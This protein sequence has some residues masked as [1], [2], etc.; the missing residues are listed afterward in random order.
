MASGTLKTGNGSASFK[1]SLF[2]KV[3]FS[4][5]YRKTDAPG[6]SAP[7]TPAW[8]VEKAV[9]F[10]RTRLSMSAN[11]VFSGALPKD[12]QSGETGVPV[13][14]RCVAASEEHALSTNSRARPNLRWVQSDQIDC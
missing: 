10:C 6:L 8:L 7:R 4:A 12:R 13:V 2:F 14:L 11:S 5:P 3:C 1:D 9:G